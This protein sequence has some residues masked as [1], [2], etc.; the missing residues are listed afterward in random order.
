MK[1]AYGNTVT[2]L[3]PDAPVFRVP[4][5]RGVSVLQQE[6]GQRKV[7]GLRV[8]LNAGICRGSVVC[9]ARV[10]GQNAVAQPLV[11]NVAGDALRLRFVI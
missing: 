3:K 2:G 6:T 7:R 8:D 10:N 1:D 4:P 5:A 11:L 9:D